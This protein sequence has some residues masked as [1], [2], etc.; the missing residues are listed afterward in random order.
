MATAGAVE[1]ILN[2]SKG[3]LDDVF[4]GVEGMFDSIGLMRGDA[5]PARR[6][7]FGVLVG[8]AAMYLIKPTVAFRQ[9]G[10]PRPWVLSNPDAPD[11]TAVP[12]WLPAAAAGFFCGFLV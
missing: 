9:D 7:V 8:G 1:K 3:P 5:A 12:W 6:L 11:K 4:H 10:R 2:G